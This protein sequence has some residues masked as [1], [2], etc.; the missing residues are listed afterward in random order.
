MDII[1][2]YIHPV[3]TDFDYTLLTQKSVVMDLNIGT[4]VMAIEDEN[5]IDSV[6]VRCKMSI[7][8]KDTN[9]EILGF[10]VE[11]G[12]IFSET[13]TPKNDLDFLVEVT[14]DMFMEAINF[15]VEN[16]SAALVKIE[17]IKQPDYKELANGILIRLIEYGLYD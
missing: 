1:K 14:E 16:S 4:Y 11:A 9:D 15:I 17:H 6:G 3:R 2:G 10:T 8:Q 7:A 5:K 12:I 13:G